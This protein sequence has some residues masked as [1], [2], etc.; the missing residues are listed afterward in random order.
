[1]QSSDA[2][3][4]SGDI[5]RHGIAVLAAR[6]DLG[7]QTDLV[8]Y[9]ALLWPAI[10]SLHAA[11]I[12]LRW[13]R[14]ATRGGL[15]TVLVQ[16]AEATDLSVL[17]DEATAPIASPVQAACDLFGFDPLY[18]AN[19]GCMVAVVPAAQG[20]AAQRVLPGAQGHGAASLTGRMASRGIALVVARN[21][22][23]GR[24]MLRYLSGEQL[25]RIC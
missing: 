9:H 5:G 24:R 1:M 16:L 12:E 7:L 17:L 15:A 21:P 20:E 3:L 11:G 13:F 10:A 2:V 8:S 19:E 6:E 18:V 22:A 25:P 14:N 4:V 23:G